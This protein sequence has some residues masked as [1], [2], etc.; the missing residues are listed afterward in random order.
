MSNSVDEFRGEP[1]VIH[2]AV[3]QKTAAGS[4]RIEE[5]DVPVSSFALKTTA[6]GG[7]TWEI[8]LYD[9]DLDAAVQKAIEIDE[10]LANKYGYIRS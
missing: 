4:R 1:E 9:D 5:A 7:H 6:R 3:E 2:G 8:K 10:T